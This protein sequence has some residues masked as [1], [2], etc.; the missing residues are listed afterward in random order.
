MEEMNVP[1]AGSCGAVKERMETP[2][3]DVCRPDR[4]MRFTKEK[5]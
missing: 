4:F 5:K 3:A 2:A 1:A